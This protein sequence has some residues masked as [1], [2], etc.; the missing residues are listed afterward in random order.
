MISGTRW[1][2]YA[3][4]VSDSHCCSRLT[5]SVQWTRLI[6]G[7]SNKKSAQGAASSPQQR[8]QRFRRAYNPVLQLCGRPQTLVSHGPALDQLH[9]SLQKIT[10]LLR[11]ES[12]TPAPHL[13]LNFAQSSQIYSVVG[14]AA[15]ASR[16]ERLVRQAIVIFGL[17]LE[18][19]DEDFVASLAFAKSLMRFA[20]RVIDSN[21]GMYGEDIEADVVEILF[22]V[23]AKI[24]I[25]PSILSVWFTTSRPTEDAQNDS[26]DFAGLT[27]KN[28]FPLCYLLIDRIHHDGRIG[29]FART[30]LLYIFEA[31]S[32]ST[33]LEDWI[34]NSDLPTLMASGLGALYS[35]LS[36][37]R[38]LLLHSL[39]SALLTKLVNCLF[40]T[41]MTT[42]L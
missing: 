29:D 19:E 7:V 28:D 24:R 31:I 38:H 6:G 25:Q 35:Q 20:L 15:T 36:R 26:K 17:L 32:H 12:R 39:V 11:E 8:L 37:Y 14:R 34:I 22:G 21:S 40:Y 1:I 9:S 30:G 18:S 5:P 27:Q 2:S 41:L 16:D 13:C 23:V 33:P 3:R 10:A 42:C 4:H